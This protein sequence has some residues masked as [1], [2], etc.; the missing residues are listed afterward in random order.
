MK[1]LKSGLILLSILFSLPSYAVL[2]YNASPDN[3]E[4][5]SIHVAQNRDSCATQGQIYNGYYMFYGPEDRIPVGVDPKYGSRVILQ[6][7]D[8]MG[9]QK[10]NVNI[11]NCVVEF[12]G[13]NFYAIQS[14]GA[15][16][17]IVSC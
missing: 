12:D 10:V 6:M 17:D 13:N 15:A 1:L 3:S 11:Q 16:C 5:I 2:L 8:G 4:R 9:A 7:G 14:S